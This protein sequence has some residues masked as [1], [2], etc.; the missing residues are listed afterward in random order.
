MA[1]GVMK[2][3]SM[4]GISVPEQLSV[5]GYDDSEFANVVW[6]D[7][8]TIRQPVKQMGELA[9]KKLIEQLKSESNPSGESMVV[10]PELVVRNSTL[11]YS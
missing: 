4:L 9:A 8:T 3:A 2:S 7:L 10:K 1:L 6:P 5:A 11:K